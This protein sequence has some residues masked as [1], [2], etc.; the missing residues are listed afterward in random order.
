MKPEDA[1][2]PPGA[3]SSGRFF[4]TGYLPTYAATVFVLVLLWA[5]APSRHVDFGRAWRVADHFGVVQ[6]LLV[7][8]AVA[9]AA[10]LFQPLQLPMIR[11]LEGRFPWLLGA[12]IAQRV[13]L[14][15]KRQ[16][17]VKI[18]TTVA[19]A[20]KASGDQRAAL[21]Q[22][23]GSLSERLRSRY[24]KQ[25][26]LVRPTAL[27]NAL[28]ALE[29][30][31]GAAYGLDAVVILPRLYPVLGDK[32]RAEL[33]DL[34][35]AMDAV[36]RL[37]VTA[38]VTTAVTVALLAWH[39]GLL[40]LM[41]LAPAAVAFLAYAGSVEAAIAYG[42]KVGVAFDLHR[43]DL[44]AALHLEIPATRAKE[45][46]HNI[47]LSDFLRQGIPVN[48][49]YPDPAPT[50]ELVSTQGEISI[51]REGGRAALLQDRGPGRTVP[52]A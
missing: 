37:T 13:R 28:T 6:A 10:V 42:A 51:E 30:T 16:L 14:R 35:D 2:Q 50:A 9:L 23:A 20:I 38:A 39:S 46:A 15:R 48:F 45:Q 19:A 40:T 11:L 8:L 17:E 32:I 49:R 1:M 26:H 7:A 25:D 18:R 24:P 22:E 43:F 31:A 34:R 47:D 12:G 33:D 4:R 29:D 36:A 41:A 44:L 3:L 27:G 5:G 21:V 52:C